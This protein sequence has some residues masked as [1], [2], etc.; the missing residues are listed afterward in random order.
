ME[1][2]VKPDARTISILGNVAWNH[3][4]STGFRQE[5]CLILRRLERQG[6]RLIL[7]TTFV[8]RRVRCWGYGRNARYVFLKRIYYGIAGCGT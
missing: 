3:T 6:I 2:A 1:T 8:E 7:V 4:F 5:F